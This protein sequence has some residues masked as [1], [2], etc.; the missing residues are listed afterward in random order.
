MT[1][2]GGSGSAG[3]PFSA[4]AYQPSHAHTCNAFSLACNMSERADDLPVKKRKLITEFFK[5]SENP[6]SYFPIGYNLTQISRKNLELD[7]GRIFPPTIANLFF[8]QLEREIKY[9]DGEFAKIKVMNKWFPLPR[10]HI[11]FGDT[12]LTY[13]FNGLCIPALKWTS[14][15][16]HLKTCVEIVTGEHFNFLLVNR[17]A[18]G[19]QTVGLHSDNERDLDPSK[20]I[21]SLSF[22][23]ERKFIFKPTRFDG[24]PLELNLENG[25]LL[26]MKPPTNQFYLHSLPRQ[27]KV[28]SPRVSLT[29]RCII[30]K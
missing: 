14:L 9:L 28:D 8:S 7:Y 2:A 27:L 25:S 29:F 11:A 26:S 3:I 5:P 15:L 19:R 16:S 13:S 20:P 17:Y 1:L 4:H 24:T 6:L 18:S 12:G 22:G 21:V 23:A 30:N 10:Q